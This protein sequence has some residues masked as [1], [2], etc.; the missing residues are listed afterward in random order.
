MSD[1][2]GYSKEPHSSGHRSSSVS[3][4]PHIITGEHG[5]LTD[6]HGNKWTITSSRQVAINGVVDTSTAAVLVIVLAYV[7]G[8]IWRQDVTAQWRSRTATTGWTPQNGT[9]ASPLG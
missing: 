3:T 9:F 5:C 2:R 4:A 1:D 6:N 7:N 8:L